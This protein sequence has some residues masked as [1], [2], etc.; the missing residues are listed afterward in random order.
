MDAW[1]VCTEARSRGVGGGGEL[2]VSLA[3]S[4]GYIDWARRIGIKIEKVKEEQIET[5]KMALLLAFSEAS[6]ISLLYDSYLNENK[7]EGIVTFVLDEIWKHYTLPSLLEQAKS[8]LF[9]PTQLIPRRVYELPHIDTKTFVM[10]LDNVL[11]TPWRCE[12]YCPFTRIMTSL[13]QWAGITFVPVGNVADDHQIGIVYIGQ[14]KMGTT[15]RGKGL[16]AILVS[17]WGCT[18]KSA[19]VPIPHPLD[20]LTALLQI[21]G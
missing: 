9:P 3:K 13:A 1:D 14:Q 12:A 17:L 19:G 21:K 11:T 2:I 20:D 10:T 16:L 18:S 4:N 15:I 7:G 6:P 8:V 5:K